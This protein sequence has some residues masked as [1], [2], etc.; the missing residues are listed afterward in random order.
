MVFKIEGP[1]GR[2]TDTL[3]TSNRI[4]FP[5][6]SNISPVSIVQVINNSIR[7]ANIMAEAKINNNGQLSIESLENGEDT[8]LKIS[9]IGLGN[10]ADIG[11]VDGGTAVGKGGVAAE[12]T[13]TTNEAFSDRGYIFLTQQSVSEIIDRFGASSGDIV[14][15]A[16]IQNVLGNNRQVATNTNQ[17]VSS[18]SIAQIINNSGLN[19]TDVTFGYDSGGRLQFHSKSVGDDSR[20]L[21]TSKDPRFGIGAEPTTFTTSTSQ[22]TLL[23]SF[24]IDGTQ[25]AQGVGKT[26]YMQYTFRIEAFHFR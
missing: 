24:G 8:S 22:T 18:A 9:L 2:E 20:I 7:S 3:N 11:M 25:A 12:F 17:A 15:A 16:G 4:Q 5:A 6:N 1:D 14:L 21:F 23:S 19:S 26:E 13:G 10:L